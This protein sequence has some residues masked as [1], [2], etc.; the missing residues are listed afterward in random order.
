MTTPARQREAERASA[1]FQIVLNQIGAKTIEDA[2]ALW[3]DIP[4]GAQP[5]TAQ[6]WLGRAVR[7]VLFRRRRSREL[8]IAYYRLARALRTGKTVADPYRDEP[9][10]IRLSELREEFALLVEGVQEAPESDLTAP[11]GVGGTEPRSEPEE[12]A[13]PVSADDDRILVERIE[14]L[15]ADIAAMERAAEEEIRKSLALLGPINEERKLRLLEESLSPEEALSGSLRDQLS[16]RDRIHAEAGK[17][18]AASSA[19]I[20]MNGARSVINAAGTRDRAVIGW[21][22]LSRT[23]TPCGWCAMLISRGPVYKSEK[24][25]LGDVDKY[26]DNCNCYAEPVYSTEQYNDSPLYALNRRYA[27]LWPQVTRGLG[28]KDALN[29]W[30]T[31]SRKQQAASAQVARSA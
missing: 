27:E 17:R 11:Q 30:R 24:T 14:R 4:P 29:V 16:E 5:A 26:H 18:Q 23:G 10:Y 13:D 9:E 22:R 31:F 8:A 7:L 20:V 25:A 6:R 15:E 1:A 21:V 19:R 12:P 28:G 3:Q 2:L